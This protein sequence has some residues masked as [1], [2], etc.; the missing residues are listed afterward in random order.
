MAGYTQM[1]KGQPLD[2]YT[3]T[4]EWC[5]SL[6]MVT[7]LLDRWRCEKSVSKIED[8]FQQRQWGLA[9]WWIVFFCCFV[10]F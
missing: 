9:H 3:Q 2:T 6:I 7:V 10:Q 8:P 5:V 1:D 4:R